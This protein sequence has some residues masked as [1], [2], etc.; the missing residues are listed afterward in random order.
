MLLPSSVTFSEALEGYPLFTISHPLCTGRVALNGAHVMEWTPSGHSPV[1]YLSPQAVLEPGKAIRGGI[2]VCWPWFNAHPTDETK[3]MHGIARNRPWTLMHASESDDGVKL[4]LVLS[5]DAATKELWPHEFQ[6]QV[7]IQM[8]SQLQV[9]LKTVN[10]GSSDITI[11]EALHTYLTVGDISLVTVKGL[12]NTGY[13]DTVGGR[14]EKHQ[15]GDI[16]F[17]REVDRQYHSTGPVT[18][19]DPALGRVLTVEKE[20]S[21]TTVVW[22]PWI[23]KSKRLADLPDE[24]YHQFLCVEAANAGDATITI[25]PGGSHEIRTTIRL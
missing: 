7:T 24:A 4:V 22:N 19:E 18:V 11:A 8:G 23:E 21:G 3:P 25:I 12:S 1:L 20:G 2:P 14:E 10:M 16:T 15:E 17:D 9:A 6:A 13:L 5:S